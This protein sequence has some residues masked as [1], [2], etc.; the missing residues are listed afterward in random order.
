MSMD[1]LI[2][3]LVAFSRGHSGSVAVFTIRGQ[4][5]LLLIQHQLLHL[6]LQVLLVNGCGVKRITHKL[7][8]PRTGGHLL[9]VIPLGLGVTK[10]RYGL[11]EE[12]TS[13]HLVSYLL[14]IADGHGRSF[15]PDLV[16]KNKPVGFS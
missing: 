2:D 15:G 13:A 8:H 9:L 10:K 4:K 14:D 6:F 1:W 16:Y 11:C 7:R 5:A 12:F 3:K